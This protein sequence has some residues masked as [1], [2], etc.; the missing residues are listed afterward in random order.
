[1]D[2]VLRKRT[3]AQGSRLAKASVDLLIGP[4]GEGYLDEDLELEDLE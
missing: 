3:G 1:M 2:L 4:D